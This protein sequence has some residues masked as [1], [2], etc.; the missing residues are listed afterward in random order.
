MNGESVIT[1]TADSTWGGMLT[2]LQCDDFVDG[3][4]DEL[5]DWEIGEYI[6]ITL[7]QHRTFRA[8]EVIERQRDG[9]ADRLRWAV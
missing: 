1:V 9:H 3:T 2:G 4:G 7:A 5:L 6:R 8:L